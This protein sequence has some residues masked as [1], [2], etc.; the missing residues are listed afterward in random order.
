MK[1]LE[2]T[3]ATPIAVTTLPGHAGSKDAHNTDQAA[4]LMSQGPT[5]LYDRVRDPR[6][7][8]LVCNRELPPPLPTPESGS[9]AR[10]AVAETRR[11]GASCFR[12]P[13]PR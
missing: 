4:A 12:K 9:G 8:L 7:G 10:R 6:I 2:S 1:R 13:G 3:A 11:G 5:P